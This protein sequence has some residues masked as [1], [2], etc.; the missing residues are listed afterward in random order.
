M[1][2]LKGKNLQVLTLE[3]FGEQRFLD[4]LAYF[5]SLNFPADAR[6]RDWFDRLPEIY[7]TRFVEWFFL[8]EEDNLVAFATIQ[9]FYPGCYRLLTRTYYNPKFRRS[10]LHYDYNDK[11]PA[12]YLIEAQLKYLKNYDTAFISMQDLK[13]RKALTRLISKLD[14]GWKLHDDM[15]R[16]CNE[17]STNCWQNIIYKGSEINLPSI[18]INEWKE[19]KD[20]ESE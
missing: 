11:T 9:E 15:I 13:R 16:T 1:S 8:V 3:Q 6:N 2:T 7:K 4:E 14:A 10:H 17:N 5:K 20:N 12:I 19:M 18:T